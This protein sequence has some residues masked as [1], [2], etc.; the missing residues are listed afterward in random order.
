MKAPAR[1]K[2]KKISTK[3]YESNKIKISLKKMNG[4]R[5]YE[6]RVLK[7]KKGKKA[8]IKKVVRKNKFTI[9]SKKL[10]NRNNL[11]VKV[12]AFKLDEKGRKL[13]GK[14]SKVKKV[15]IKK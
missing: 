4:I 5:G 6:V 11:Y 10:R 14:W 8:L 15:K 13:F 3:K 1:A 7:K 9:K 12:R 2:I